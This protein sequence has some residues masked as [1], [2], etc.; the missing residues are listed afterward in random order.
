LT[1]A[2]SVNPRFPRTSINFDRNTWG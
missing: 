1:A 2:A